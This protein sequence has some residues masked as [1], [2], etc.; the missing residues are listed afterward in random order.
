MHRPLG[1]L[2]RTFLSL[3][4]FNST[5]GS[6]RFHIVQPKVRTLAR[7]QGVGE[8]VLMHP[9][10]FGRFLMR[11]H[12]LSDLMGGSDPVC[13]CIPLALVLSCN[14]IARY[15]NEYGDLATRLA[16]TILHV[17]TTKTTGRRSRIIV[18]YYL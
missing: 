7:A 4:G 18:V 13:G 2:L 15:A 1:S 10:R 3:S 12:A 14:L 5:L 11:R 6:P 8:G 17:Q 16:L 9:M